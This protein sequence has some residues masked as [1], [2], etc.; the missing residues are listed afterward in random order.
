MFSPFNPFEIFNNRPIPSIEVKVFNDMG[1]LNYTAN[2]VGNET[3]N[4]LR[5][6]NVWSILTLHTERRFFTA[7]DGVQCPEYKLKQ[8]IPSSVTYVYNSPY[9]GNIKININYSSII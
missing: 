8:G 2:P 9:R 6:F 5:D 4:I 1:H 7:R 3:E